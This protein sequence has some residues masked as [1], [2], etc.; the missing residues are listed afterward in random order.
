MAK[1]T[2]KIEKDGQIFYALIQLT[3]DK[4]PFFALGEREMRGKSMICADMY[5]K[6]T[7]QITKNCTV[8]IDTKTIVQMDNQE[9]IDLSKATSHIDPITPRYWFTNTNYD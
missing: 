3:F 9:D 6:K 4:D 8:H 1:Q 7:D 5:D 2:D